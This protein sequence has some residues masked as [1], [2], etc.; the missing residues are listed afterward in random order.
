MPEYR[1]CHQRTRK[2]HR[3]SNLAPIYNSD[4]TSDD[5][6]LLCSLCSKGSPGKRK[7][8]QARFRHVSIITSWN[9][10]QDKINEIGTQ[11]FAEETNQ[12]LVNLHSIDTL[13]TMEQWVLWN[14]PPDMTDHKEGKLSLCLG[15][16]ILIKKNIATE[17]C[18]TN[19]AEAIVVG[20]Q[21]NEVNIGNLT[22]PVADVL[23]VELVNPPYDIKL[24]GL[25]TNVV[26]L[27]RSL[28][29]LECQLPNGSTNSIS[30]EQIDVEP[31]QTM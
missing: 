25:P 29:T 1:G 16:P 23:F 21:L 20:W 26:P 31:R 2:H 19:R 14:L 6:N 9:R 17:C 15:M 8:E 12:K 5:I 11:K 3:K 7:L 13:T 27:T 30:R 10:Y 18:V 22:V 28:T 24:E 4:C